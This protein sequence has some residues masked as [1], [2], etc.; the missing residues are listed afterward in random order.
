MRVRITGSVGQGTWLQWG[1]Q[2]SLE[3]SGS[4]SIGREESGYTKYRTS[5]G[6]PW[7]LK[8]LHKKINQEEL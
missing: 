6:S 8:E 4:K 3:I 2:S 7:E 1:I 5:I